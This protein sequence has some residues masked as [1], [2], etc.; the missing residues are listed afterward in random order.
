MVSDTCCGAQARQTEVRQRQ[1]SQ[2]PEAGR[3]YCLERGAKI[4]SENS[5]KEKVVLAGFLSGCTHDRA[6]RLSTNQSV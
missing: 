5:Q 2:E 3:G 1:D 4:G 6:P